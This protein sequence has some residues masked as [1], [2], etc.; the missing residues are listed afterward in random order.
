[1]SNHEDDR[2][3]RDFLPIFLAKWNAE[4]C[5]DYD[6]YSHYFAFFDCC[7]DHTRLAFE[8]ELIDLVNFPNLST[9]AKCQGLTYYKM[10]NEKVIAEFEERTGYSFTTITQVWKAKKRKATD[11]SDSDE[12]GNPDKHSRSDLSPLPQ[13]PNHTPEIGGASSHSHELNNE[14]AMEESEHAPP[15][16]KG[17]PTSYALAAASQTNTKP[18][19]YTIYAELKTNYAKDLE[20]ISDIIGE[21]FT[22]TLTGD[23]HKMVIPDDEKFRR[24]QKY[25]NENNIGFQTMDPKALRPKKYI[26]KGIPASTPIAEIDAFLREKGLDP[27]SIN[28][29]FS[30]KLQ[31]YWAIALI[32]LRPNA[33]L[34]EIHR[35]TQFGRLRVTTEN[36]RD[37]K[38]PKQ[39]HN[40]LA[41]GHH[42]ATCTL[43]PKCLKCAGNHTFSSCP[44][45]L[46][47][48][49]A[50]CTNCQGAHVATYRGCPRNPANRNKNKKT[51]LLRSKETTAIQLKNQFA[52]LIPD[53][54]EENPETED[55][56]EM[57]AEDLNDKNETAQAEK[58]KTP[59]A[60]QTVRKN[61]MK[62]NN[63][64][65]TTPI[66][67]A[68]IPPKENVTT[69]P[70]KGK[71]KNKPS[72]KQDDE[73]TE[74]VTSVL[75]LFS[76]MKELSQLTDITN[77]INFIRE[78]AVKIKQIKKPV[79]Q[80]FEL[81]SIYN[82][83]FNKNNNGSE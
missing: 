35:I 77:M 8:S 57:E 7:D 61:K 50:K 1:M 79:D 43:A 48:Q 80:V 66:G 37:K 21:D 72:P 26:I 11:E 18:V 75:E 47:K 25:L 63:A 76:A 31:K 78:V 56:A 59:R 67:M 32:S 53:E 83:Y 3:P 23:R 12:D 24:V 16:Q 40:C 49:E 82:K 13:V 28:F 33:N 73:S 29:L 34:D 74:S 58:K 44:V 39:C 62:Q 81:W 65:R 14:E 69:N 17:P 22:S 9:L 27:V 64:E 71:R 51:H 42:S 52:A 46:K 10:L 36:Y 54:P 2:V 6:L 15:T 5:A 68:P 20:A 55:P 38:K 41:Y 60:N 45:K 30:K 4:T 70:T 19:K